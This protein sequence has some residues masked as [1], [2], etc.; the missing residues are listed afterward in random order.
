MKF[1]AL[2]IFTLINASLC[3]AQFGKG[4]QM[5][6]GNVNFDLASSKNSTED[7]VS[8]FT[9]NNNEED[10]YG[11]GIE[12]GY[13][14]FK[15][16][17]TVWVFGLGYSYMLSKV[18]QTLSD[19]GRSVKTNSKNAD[20]KYTLF[21]ENLNFIPIKNN[22]GLT[23]SF[24]SLLAYNTL[25]SNSKSNYYFNYNDSSFIGENSSDGANYLVSFSGNLGAYYNINKHFLLFSQ[26]N[27]VTAN[28]NFF[29]NTNTYL[30][31]VRKTENA[32]FG[33]D[34]VGALTPAFKLGDIS[35]GIQ[36][37]IN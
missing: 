36:Y 32:G 28:L 20:Y 15:K 14:K 24:K 31:N 6:S 3:R 35:I 26:L 1:Y 10:K 21:A 27:V 5:L 37:L 29:N 30:G 25:K 9:K 34:L 13:G 33:F 19:T 7:Y 12:L 17:N 2:I 11:F 4:S 18:Y 8:P 16:E 22:W 23:Y